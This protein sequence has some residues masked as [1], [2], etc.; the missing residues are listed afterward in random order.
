[1]PATTVN[2]FAVPAKTL[3]NEI[4]PITNEQ[5]AITTAHLK[6]FEKQ[7]I[8]TRTTTTK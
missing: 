6:L 3:Q 4:K 8:N 7:P 5:F 2:L 1:V